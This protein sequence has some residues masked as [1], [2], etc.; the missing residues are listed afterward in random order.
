[1]LK[2]LVMGFRMY[3]ISFGKKKKKK[4]LQT[5]Y[6]TY[7]RKNGINRY[8]HILSMYDLF[9]FCK[10]KKLSM[11]R[12]SVLHDYHIGIDFRYSCRRICISIA[13]H[14]KGVYVWYTSICNMTK[15]LD[16]SVITEILF[17]MKLNFFKK[18]N[19]NYY[20]R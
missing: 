16:V 11:H 6:G 4:Q 12:R 14:N 18:V 20:V 8:E 5:G 3:N 7:K 10:L 17:D 13:L 19:K 1:M 9:Y 2:F 15:L